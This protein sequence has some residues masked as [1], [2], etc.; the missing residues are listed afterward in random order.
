MPGS[1]SLMA[2]ATP[3]KFTANWRRA[4]T[5]DSSAK[6]P[7]HMMAAL[8]T[9]TSSGPRRWCTAERKRDR[10]R[11]GDVHAES[12]R[13]A[14]ELAGTLL[15]ELTIEVAERDARARIGELG[16]D[17]QADAPRSSGDGNDPARD[18]PPPR[19]CGPAR[20]DGTHA[21]GGDPRPRRREPAEGGSASASALV[22]VAEAK[23]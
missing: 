9:S 19:A 12:Q 13:P 14:A 3:W 8:H 7:T 5:S 16:G 10:V 6:G 20:E 15:G 2:R 18:G 21:H 17:G 1:A 22:G 4:T 11:G 23:L